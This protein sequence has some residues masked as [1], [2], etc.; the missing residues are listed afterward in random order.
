MMHIMQY[1][2]LE[3]HTSVC[4]LACH[5]TKAGEE[6]F[7]AMLHVMKYYVCTPNQ[8]DLVLKLDGIWDENL[9]CKTVL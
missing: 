3:I 5:M 2:C 1:C 7:T 9:D 8:H 4:N 6:Q